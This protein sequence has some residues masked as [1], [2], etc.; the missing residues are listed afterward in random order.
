LGGN[1]TSSFGKSSRNRVEIGVIEPLK[2]LISEA[3]WAWNRD[4]PA[5][6]VDIILRG[7]EL[8]SSPL[9]V[10]CNKKPEII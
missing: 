6:F 4:F 8:K 10:L 5:D 7:L 9:F 1:C 2:K 3:V